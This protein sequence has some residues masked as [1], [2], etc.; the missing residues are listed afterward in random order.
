[1]LHLSAH[2]SLLS[3]WIFP[4]LVQTP[5]S[6]S[7]L[8]GQPCFLSAVFASLICP[9][10]TIHPFF[11]LHLRLR[12]SHPP[13]PSYYHRTRYHLPSSTPLH[14]ITTR[15]AFDSHSIFLSALITSD[16]H[17]HC[18]SHHHLSVLSTTIFPRL[19]ND[20]RHRFRTIHLSLAIQ[21]TFI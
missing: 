14:I 6:S 8:T 1:V 16:L 4:L 7:L 19:A 20:I 9:N 2:L 12:F 18:A 11:A 21:S 17:R 15:I 3:S 10:R 13:F 5:S